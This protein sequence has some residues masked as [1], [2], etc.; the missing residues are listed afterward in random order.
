MNETEARHMAKRERRTECLAWA[1]MEFGDASLGDG[2]R[3][4]RLTEMAASALANPHGPVT[5]VFTGSAEREGA[6]RLIENDAIH[7]DDVGRSAHV[8]SFRRAEGRHVFVP[9]DGSSLSI[10]TAADNPSFGPVGTDNTTTRGIEVMSAIAVDEDG[11]PLG[12]CGQR[13]W[14]R[15]KTKTKKKSNRPLEEK[16]TRHWL[17]VQEQAL[18]AHR[19]SG[20]S[21]ELWFQL[22]RGG[23]FREAL[24]W[25]SVVDAKVT[26]RVAQDRRVVSPDDTRLWEAVEACEPLGDYELKVPRRPKRT[27][28]KA[29]MEVRATPVV[30][31]LGEG[32][33]AVQ[34]ELYAVHTKEVSPA[35]AGE[36]PIEWLLLTNHQV[37]ALDDARLVIYGYSLRWRIEE[38]H[39]TWKSTCGVEASALEEPDRLAIWATV[40]FAVAVRIERLKYIARTS[41]TYPATVDLR[42][43]EIRALRPSTGSYEGI[44]CDP[45]RRK[46]VIPRAVEV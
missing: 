31:V 9:V 17:D 40:L 41:P 32:K 1:A 29:R 33:Q 11:T 30:L 18:A 27:A 19:A 36:E 5:A 16:E 10:P 44:P 23:D 45:R 3:T 7:V 12:V 37:S 46:P 6:Y 20:T 39:K 21:A 15:R 25:A 4:K 2:R 38:V 26:V 8:A 13:Y 35:P 22:D 42:R 24:M 34:V 43:D 14:T 28:R